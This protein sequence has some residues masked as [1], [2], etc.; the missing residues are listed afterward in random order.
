MADAA[1]LDCLVHVTLP[2][3]EQDVVG[4]QG[5][6]DEQLAAPMTIGMLLA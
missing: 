4:A 6:I 2:V 3:H 1:L 5:A